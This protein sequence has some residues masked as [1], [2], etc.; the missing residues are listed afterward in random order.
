MTMCATEL[1]SS[2]ITSGW[3]AETS[4]NAMISNTYNNNSMIVY[5]NIKLIIMNIVEF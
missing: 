1:T 2:N 3:V 5:L 4:I